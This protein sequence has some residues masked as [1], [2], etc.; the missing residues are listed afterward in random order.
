ML[1]DEGLRFETRRYTALNRN[2]IALLL[3]LAAF[4]IGLSQVRHL[5]LQLEFVL[6]QLDES[7]LC[8]L[9]FLILLPLAMTMALIWKTKEV[10]FDSVFGASR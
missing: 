10:I 7:G 8:N 5:P 3:L 6:A 1:P 9:L 4:Y 2:L